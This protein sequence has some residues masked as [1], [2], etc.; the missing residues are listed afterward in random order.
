MADIGS[1][2]QR[3]QE[4]FQILPGI[5]TRY[6]RDFLNQANTI[7]DNFIKNKIYFTFG[8]QI[9]NYL[10]LKR[11]LRKQYVNKNKLEGLIQSIFG[12]IQ[13]FTNEQLRE[14]IFEGIDWV[15][16]MFQNNYPQWGLLTENLYKD[17]DNNTTTFKSPE[18]IASFAWE[19]LKHNSLP[20]CVSDVG[21]GMDYVSSIK[22]MYENHD[23]HNFIMFDDCAYSG[24][25]KSVAVF[26]NTWEELTSNPN[27][28]KPFNIIVVIPFITVK[29]VDAFRMKAS[30]YGS[31][32]NREFINR[33][34]NYCQ[35]EDTINK[36]S[37]FLWGGKVVMQ[38]TTNI[39]YNKVSAM[40]T[41]TQETYGICNDLYNFI[42]NDILTDVGGT[43]GAAMCLFEHK[44]PDFVS[45]P[46]VVADI[47]DAPPLDIN[48]SDN[49]PYKHM[50]NHARPDLSKVFECY[51]KA[52]NGG[53]TVKKQ[54][55]KEKITYCKKKYSVLLSKRGHKYIIHNDRKVYLKS[56][57]HL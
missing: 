7:K 38:N 44:L 16:K 32:F 27:V 29:A 47:F 54:K 48:Y 56:L 50:S 46:T 2:I 10:L 45:L 19:K 21:S 14:S 31:G 17:N 12:E 43:L 6:S 49:P 4:N 41:P 15:S 39:V 33:D 1:T 25:Q 24:I 5:D 8:K 51:K 22:D 42:I 28:K 13:I 55:Q 37:V 34:H 18:W 26:A 35:W 20:F 11:E 57:Q 23:I 3:Y 53:A 36:R 9:D 52:Q 40:I 30:T